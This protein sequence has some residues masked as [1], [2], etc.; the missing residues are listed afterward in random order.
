MALIVSTLEG[1]RDVIEKGG[2]IAVLENVP[3]MTVDTLVHYFREKNLL[4]AIEA[5]DLYGNPAPNTF[6]IRRMEPENADGSI[7]GELIFENL[8][9]IEKDQ[10]KYDFAEQY[11]CASFMLVTTLQTEQMLANRPWQPGVEHA[12]ARLPRQKQAA[13]RK[14][15]REILK[16]EGLSTGSL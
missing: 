13:A 4:V 5:G 16:N 15:V 7:P 6:T 11:G 14:L 2:G 8:T 3:D 12:I 10:L 9:Q 1:A